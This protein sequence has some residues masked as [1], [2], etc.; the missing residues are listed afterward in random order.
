M[1]VGTM[2]SFIAVS[3]GK[4]A[5]EVVERSEKL[6]QALEAHA[7][8]AEAVPWVFLALTLVYGSLL[9]PVF[10]RSALS[11]RWTMRLHVLF[12]LIY[13]VGGGWLA[14]AAH[15]GG[16]LVHQLGVHAW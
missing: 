7:D 14:L 1:L 12:L 3:T 13:A 6:E 2:A 16:I 9:S 15:R 10:M 5:G 8:M 11:A 4:A